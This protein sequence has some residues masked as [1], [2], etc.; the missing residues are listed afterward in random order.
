MPLVILQ[1]AALE[2]D[3]V[4]GGLQDCILAAFEMDCNTILPLGV[5][6]IMSFFLFVQRPYQFPM[7][8]MLLR[9]P[10]QPSTIGFHYWFE[11]SL[12]REGDPSH[13]LEV[14]VSVWRRLAVLFS[15]VLVFMLR[16][17]ERPLYVIAPR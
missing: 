2:F 16:C 12:V 17:L 6:A 8:P 7:L 5:G 4:F 11:K 14:C 13:I 1:S 10:L 3:G 9:V 15:G